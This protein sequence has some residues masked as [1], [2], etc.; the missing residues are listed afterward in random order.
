MR[1]TGAEFKR[2]FGLSRARFLSAEEIW[3][4]LDDADT[5]GRRSYLK[6]FAH[7]AV[8]GIPELNTF[9]RQ[10]FSWLLIR[11]KPSSI[12]TYRSTIAKLSTF[13]HR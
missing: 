6:T 13:L 12:L 11:R 5:D 2:D 10:L 4:A 7:A 1:H 3:L 9:H 8:I